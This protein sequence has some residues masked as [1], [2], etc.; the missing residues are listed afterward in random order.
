MRTT[1]SSESLNSLLN[2]SFPKHPHIFKFVESLKLFEFSKANN[3][4]DFATNEVPKEQFG[5]KRKTDQERDMKIKHFSGLLKNDEISVNDFL[6]AMA[7][8]D[9][10][11]SI[12]KKYFTYIQDDSQSVL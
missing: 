5:R 12:G 10:L 11:P 9:M 2:R 7:N 8:K 3:M 1:S 4:L 6:E